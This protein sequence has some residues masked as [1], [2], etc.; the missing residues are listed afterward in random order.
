MIRNPIV[1]FLAR[2]D[3]MIAILG[4]AVLTCV[5][6][7]GVACPGHAA[8]RGIEADLALAH[9]K[10]DEL[11]GMLLEHGQ[12]QARLQQHRDKLAEM[13]PIIP[14][15]SH[16]AEVLCEVAE[17]A[18]N[19]GLTVNRLEPLSTVEFASYSSHPFQLSCRGDFQNIAS[20]LSGLETHSR[21][22]TFGSLDLIHGNEGGTEGA[23][24]VQA[25]IHFSVYSRQSKSTKLAEN[26]I[27]NGSTR[28]DN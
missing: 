10:I 16:V 17:L 28:S 24:F 7:F 8:A 26:T 22:V 3:T 4:T 23:R 14:D 2:H 1:K 12:L 11:P 9:A 21:L 20:F 13:D 6:Y 25:S 18:A 5:Y 15:E 19:A 27:S